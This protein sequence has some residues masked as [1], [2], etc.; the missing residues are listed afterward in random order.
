MALSVEQLFPS[1]PERVLPPPGTPAAARQRLRRARR[2]EGKVVLRVEVI[3]AE[4]VKALVG[5]GFLDAADAG[6]RGRVEAMLGRL[7][8]LLSSVVG[9]CAR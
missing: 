4:L 5:G 7:V 3:E 8:R 6:N 9:A 1:L 2:R